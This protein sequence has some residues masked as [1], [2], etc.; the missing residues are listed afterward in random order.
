MALRLFSDLVVRLPLPIL[1][2]A[3]L[4][5]KTGCHARIENT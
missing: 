3:A 5:K 4:V 1:Q 2:F